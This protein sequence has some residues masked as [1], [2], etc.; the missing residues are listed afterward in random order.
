MSAFDDDLMPDL[1]AER[2]FYAAGALLTEDDF[3]TEQ[4]YHRG[5]L[6]RV[7]AYLHGAG[8][9]A[10]LDVRVEPESGADAEIRTAPIIILGASCLWRR[11]ATSGSS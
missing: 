1:A 11:G 2:V 10:G 6:G 8:T 3:R 4:R 7:L 9:I 5:R